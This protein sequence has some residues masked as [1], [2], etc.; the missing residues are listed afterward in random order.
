MP[1]SPRHAHDRQDQQHNAAGGP[2]TV[3]RLIGPVL[4]SHRGH[5]GALAAWSVVETVPVLLS[6]TI[7]GAALDRGFLAGRPG[8][9]LLLLL[10]YGGCLV[11][12][13]F[14]TRQAMPHAAAV[15]ESLRDALTRHVVR[16]GLCRAVYGDGAAPGPSADV[17]AVTRATRQVETV[18][19][20]AG[21]LL[22]TLRT[23]AFGVVA[24]LVGLFAL[25]PVIAA[26]TGGSVLV[27]G[28]LMT[29]LTPLL[30]RRHVALLEAQEELARR[31]GP[32]LSGIR[33]VATCGAW[34]T[35]TRTVGGCVDAEAA[36]LLAEA[37]AGT[38]R[39]AVIAA[40]ARLPFAV[41]LLCSAWLVRSGLLT[42]GALIGAM[43]YLLQGIEPA[44]RALVQTVGTMGLQLSVTL[45]R[46]AAFADVVPPRPGGTA[47]VTG[48][49]VAL[50]DVSF[51]YGP[52]AEPVLSRVT[53]R[54]P[55]GS[56][57]AVVGPSGVGKSTLALLIGG[58]E[59]PAGGTVTLGGTPVGLLDTAE[60]RRHVAV[61]PQQ[62]YI[63][64][65]TLRENLTMLSPHATDTELEAAI[66]LLG[67]EGTVRRLGGYG[68]RIS[69]SAP[70]S[71]GERQLI[72][73][74]RVY[75]SRARIVILD[76]ATCHLEPAAEKRAE[77]AF[78]ARPGTLIVVAHRLSSALRARR[79]AVVAS[80]RL[81][82]GTHAELLDRAPE[83]AA[84]IGHWRSGDPLGRREPVRYGPVGRVGARPGTRTGGGTAPAALTEPDVEAEP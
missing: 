14:G 17:S 77:E 83:Y 56:H 58:I 10:G 39:I 62:S 40:G 27:A 68:A 11:L 44:L 45:R 81:T 74:V 32:H 4:R 43:V 9:G 2:L 51:A 64:A 15:V 20:L 71:Q 3:R 8:L 21:G 72:T 16:A 84:L 59:H 18:R 55:D 22:L 79:I 26:V 50:T 78:A 41:V 82:V 70:L 24:A 28:A 63:F 36:A 1:N 19:Q 23:V 57:L 61:V 46:T 54:V 7:V 37:R 12:G 53:L 60:L 25:D 65:G 30:R 66:S 49:D 73:L 5:L 42:P 29:R 31:A 76:E 52:H 35:A 38:G 34:E 6:G 33:D 80:G 13:T 67:L 48:S 75:V 47:P 69:G